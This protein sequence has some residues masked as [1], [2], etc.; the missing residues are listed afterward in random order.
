MIR[1][2]YLAPSLGLAPSG[3]LAPARSSIFAIP[4][5]IV[6]RLLPP[7]SANLAPEVASLPQP[8]LGSALPPSGSLR[9]VTG[10]VLKTMQEQVSPL[11]LS[12]P[13]PQGHIGVSIKEG[14]GACSLFLANAPD[15]ERRY[16]PEAR[17]SAQKD[18]CIKNLIRL[19]RKDHPLASLDTYPHFP[20]NISTRKSR[21]L[22]EASQ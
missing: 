22:M 2:S 12:Y 8:R 9:P 11:F 16:R 20:Y 5:K 21:V 3:L 18:F 7:P 19:A 14:A 13:K 1:D 17:G 6:A 10:F 15:S 4:A